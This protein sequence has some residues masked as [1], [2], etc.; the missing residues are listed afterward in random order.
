VHPL[1]KAPVLEDGD[2]KIAES[3]VIIGLS[4]RY[5]LRLGSS[6]ICPSEYLIDSYGSK[7]AVSPKNKL[8]DAYCESSLTLSRCY[9]VTHEK[10]GS[11]YSEGTLMPLLTNKLIYSVVP[12]KS[13]LFVRPVVSAIMSKLNEKIVEPQLKANCQMVQSESSEAQIN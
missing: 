10:P 11:H 7:F 13:P 5:T 6:H 9:T 3:A 12:S 8:Q 1:G 4:P 2:V